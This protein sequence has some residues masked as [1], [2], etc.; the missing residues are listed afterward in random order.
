MRFSLYYYLFIFLLLSN[1]CIIVDVP[2]ISS[3][4]I[5]SS[6][7]KVLFS[8]DLNNTVIFSR[9]SLI[10]FQ[11]ENSVILKSVPAGYNYAYAD[12]LP[13]NNDGH[14]LLV[15]MRAPLISDF[16]PGNL[17]LTE[18]KDFGNTWS[19]P[20]NLEEN[21]KN[22]YINISSPSLIRISENHIMLFY[23]VKYSIGRIDRRFVESFDNGK[24]WNKSQLVFG[25][26]KGYQTSNNA[27]VTYQNGRI[28]I[29]IS[30]PTN[31]Y[32]MY[33]N[34]IEDFGVFYYYSDDLG[35]TWNR[36]NVLINTGF[37]LLEPG[38][39]QLTN[40]EY[41]M[42]IRTNK[43]KVLFARSYNKGGDWNFEVA[44]I[45][46]TN[47]PQTLYSY[48]D[49]LL[50]IWN[51]RTNNNL[52]SGSR[53]ILS[54]SISYDKGKNWFYLFDIENSNLNKSYASISEDNTFFYIT[55]YELIYNHTSSL[56]L[57][58]IRK[59]DLF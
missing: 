8:V 17:I 47:S 57:V 11:V 3:E 58:K 6:D 50:M 38:L 21:F 31:K 13:L 33:D 18:S 5:I 55:Y 30:I 4:D 46:T 37:G 24:T 14:L 15:S 19:I 34:T 9:D 39:L 32:Q 48:K 7:S 53:T 49:L 54:F 1:S 56:K 26:N 29:P 12:L 10:N 40:N 16:A 59:S 22:D 36:S 52:S 41:L 27:R 35:R 20:V 43:G 44:N 28:M 23:G 2:D 25:D 42:N 45:D 51:K